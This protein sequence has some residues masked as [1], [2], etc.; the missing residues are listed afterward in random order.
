MI[1]SRIK[2]GELHEVKRGHNVKPSNSNCQI[3]IEVDT[4]VYMFEEF[5]NPQYASFEY[6]ADYV[7]NLMEY[8]FDKESVICK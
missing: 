6:L 8:I 4:P 2:S 3:N 5:R 1:P 7:I